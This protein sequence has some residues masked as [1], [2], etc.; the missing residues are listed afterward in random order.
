MV[1]NAQFTYFTDRGK[2]YTNTVW[3]LPRAMP[4]HDG[5]EYIKQAISNGYLPGLAGGVWDGYI[6]VKFEEDGLQRLLLPRA[7]QLPDENPGHNL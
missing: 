4:Y 2:F 7:S 1:K 5:I 6:L 3:D